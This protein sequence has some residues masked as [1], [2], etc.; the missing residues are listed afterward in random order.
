M[1]VRPLDGTAE[2]AEA[3]SLQRIIWG[4]GDLEILP[5]RLFVTAVNVGGMALGAFDEDR[6]VGFCLTIPGVKRTSPPASYLHSHMLCVL[7]DYRDRGVGRLLK[8]AQRDDA[9]A[10]G[11]DLIEWTF[12]PLQA[13]NAYFNL[14]RL[15]AIVRRYVRNMY[16][17]TGSPLHGGLPTD[18]CVAEWWIAS[19]R[20]N[21]ALSGERPVAAIPCSVP[22]PAERDLDTQQQFGD[23][24]ESHFRRGL[25]V[26]GFDRSGTGS[27]LLEPW[28]SR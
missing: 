13:K 10:R 6:L 23:I 24:L 3:V 12:D 21:Q 5:V 26:T 1:T 27:Y 18:R 8:L 4:F 20:V 16:G 15:G 22:L 11:F 19:V 9:I 28:P 25:A 17:A 7:E 2:Y 14:E